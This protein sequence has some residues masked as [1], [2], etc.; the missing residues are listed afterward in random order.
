MFGLDRR[1][2]LKQSLVPLALSGP[3]LAQAPT[4]VPRRRPIEFGTDRMVSAIG[5]SWKRGTGLALMTLRHTCRGAF[6]CM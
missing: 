2:F 3:A 5:G 6:A 4:P 1:Q